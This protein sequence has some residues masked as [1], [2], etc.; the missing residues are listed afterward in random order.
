MAIYIVPSDP[1]AGD[2]E[3]TLFSYPSKNNSHFRLVVAPEINSDSKEKLGV[4]DINIINTKTI[5]MKHFL[6]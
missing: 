1:I 5:E 6:I 4:I 3:S 2:E